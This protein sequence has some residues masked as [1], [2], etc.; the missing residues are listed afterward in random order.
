ML[1]KLRNAGGDQRFPTRDGIIVTGDRLQT[2]LAL[3][4]GEKMLGPLSLRTTALNRSHV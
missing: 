1:L 4:G 3:Q 2:V